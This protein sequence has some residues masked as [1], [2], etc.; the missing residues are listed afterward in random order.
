MTGLNLETFLRLIRADFG[1]WASLGVVLL[2]LSVMTWTSWGSRKALRKCLVLS[3]AAHLG[4]ISYGSTSPIV[5]RVLRLG[6]V[7]RKP[8]A[9]VERVRVTPWVEPE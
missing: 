6:A 4:L 3:I 9:T 7:E 5:L 8:P 2:I 1:A